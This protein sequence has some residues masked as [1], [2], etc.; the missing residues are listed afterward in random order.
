MDRRFPETSFNRVPGKPSLD[1]GACPRSR[2]P[3]YRPGFE[4]NLI[5][6]V[7][8]KMKTCLAQ[9]LVAA[10]AATSLD[11]A[12]GIVFGS[13]SGSRAAT[14]GFDV[15][16]GGLEVVL[17]NTSLADT[18]VP[19]DVLTGVFFDITGN[20]AL[21]R[22]SA[23]TGG[24]T[25]RGTTFISG[26][27]AAVGGE[28]AYRNSLSQY[29]ADSGISSSG[30]GLFGPANIFPGANLSGPASP[31]GTSYG[32][33]SAADI[34]STGNG[35]VLGNEL[36]KNSVTFLLGGLPAHFSLSNIGNVTFQY[37][38]SLSEPHMAWN[39]MSLVDAARAPNAVVNAV[40]EPATLGLAGVGLMALLAGRR[41]RADTR[42][43]CRATASP[44][45]I[46]ASA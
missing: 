18:L 37:G 3:G 13:S 17:S 29:A 11:A 44:S 16:G 27:G 30:L 6:E 40:A 45:S 39:S 2:F 34:Q 19:S 5:V 7:T 33:A 28:W 38:T 20:P 22:I 1:I 23:I 14:A 21:T 26:A 9:T 46:T 4:S 41:R 25:Y 15:V 31:A 42:Q 12:A 36:T 32:L 10:M 8:E 43:R 24:P 35:G